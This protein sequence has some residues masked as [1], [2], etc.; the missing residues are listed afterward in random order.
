M[1]KF[2]NIGSQLLMVVK[3]YF[4]SYK[5]MSLSDRNL[6]KIVF[7]WTHTSFTLLPLPNS[8]SVF[9][10]KVS[11]FWYYIF[12]HIFFFPFFFFLIRKDK[13]ES[14]FHSLETMCCLFSGRTCWWLVPLSAT[15]SVPSKSTWVESRW[16]L[17][18]GF[19]SIYNELPN[20]SFLDV[21]SLLVKPKKID[22]IQ[23]PNTSYYNNGSNGPQN[24][25]KWVKLRLL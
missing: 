19:K 20:L 12:L 25:N 24:G 1:L 17:M 11:S 16:F 18:T 8:F 14:N 10:P 15:A 7:V 13:R 2:G 23:S 3:S 9:D 22:W 5:S 6:S 4:F 21:K